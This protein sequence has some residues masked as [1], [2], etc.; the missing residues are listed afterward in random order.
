MYFLIG[1]NSQQ[2]DL[3]FISKVFKKEERKG[4][5]ERGREKGRER[6]RHWQQN[7]PLNHIIFLKVELEKK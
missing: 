4:G 1:E 7:E 2:R 6:E 5:S 3:I